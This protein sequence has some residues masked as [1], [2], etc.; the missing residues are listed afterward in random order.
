MVTIR[1]ATEAD[2]E[3]LAQL[4][5][6]VHI[7]AQNDR[8]AVDPAVF[9]TGVRAYLKD[10][11]GRSYR[12][13]LAEEGGNIVGSIGLVLYRRPPTR[14]NMDGAEGLLMGFEHTLDRGTGHSLIPSFVREAAACARGLGA[15]RLRLNAPDADE[16]AAFEKAGFSGSPTLLQLGL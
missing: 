11:L 8:P 10:N 15:R 5:T 6:T 4:R 2:I 12:A 13:W 7:G 3:G 16:R 1:E 9:T 14:D